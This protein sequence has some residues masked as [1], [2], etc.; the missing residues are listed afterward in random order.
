MLVNQK[1]HLSEQLHSTG[2]TLCMLSPRSSWQLPCTPWNLFKSFP[3]HV[4]NPLQTKFEL[5]QYLETPPLVISC[6]YILQANNLMGHVP[7]VIK[8]PL[9]LSSS[10]LPVGLTQPLQG[11]GY[12]AQNMGCDLHMYIKE[13]SKAATSSNH[14]RVLSF[15]RDFHHLS[16]V[17]N[18][19]MVWYCVCVVAT[20]PSAP[21]LSP[22][23]GSTSHKASR[24]W[25]SWYD[26]ALWQSDLR[27]I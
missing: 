20:R 14:A 26:L 23:L 22:T 5:G 21:G 17:P 16:H 6:H 7:N 15:L 1:P 27:L 4:P 12:S 2:Q 3:I 8:L 10:S 9:L 13:T 25:Y 19:I 18:V 11:R 24:K